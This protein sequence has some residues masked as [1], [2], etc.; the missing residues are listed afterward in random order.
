VLS[1]VHP[2]F[3]VRLLPIPKV[4][5]LAFPSLVEL[6]MLQPDFG[7]ISNFSSP[8]EKTPILIGVFSVNDSMVY[9]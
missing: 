7:G 8:T 6:I 1:D 5:N 9:V 4:F 3:R 2:M